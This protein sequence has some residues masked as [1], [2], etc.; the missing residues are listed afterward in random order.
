MTRDALEAALRGAD[1]TRRLLAFARRQPL[2]PRRADVNALIAE[3]TKLLARTLG[4]DIEIELDRAPDLWSVV[5]DPVQL[6]AAITNLANNARDAMPNG[7]R[8][9]IATRNGHIDAEHAALSLDVAPGDYVIIEVTDTGTGMT[10]EIQG[11]IFDPFFTTKEPGKGT[12]LGL[13]MVFG[14]IRQS[15]GHI[16]VYSEVGSGTTLRLHLPRGHHD[17]V[18]PGEHRVAATNPGGNE[19][20]LVVEDNAKLLAVVVK[21]LNELGYR[22]LAADHARA[23]MAILDGVEPVDLMLTDIVMPGGTNGIDLAHAAAERRPLLKVLLTSGF[24][25]ARLSGPSILQ[26]GRR[27]LSKPYRKDELARL[28]R[29]ILDEPAPGITPSDAA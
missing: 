19:T 24:P 1:L 27:L 4:E 17:G 14:F 29:E 7:G 5:V 26:R 3:I 8:L 13:S 10:P 2:Q 20:I 22:V 23:A 11:R 12:G 18:E 25:E 15:G 6:E 28:V 9:I 21:Q 16:G